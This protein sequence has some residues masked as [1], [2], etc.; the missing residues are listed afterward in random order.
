MVR[1]VTINGLTVN[2]THCTLITRMNFPLICP[3][4]GSRVPFIMGMIACI[5]YEHYMEKSVY[6]RHDDFEI[7]VQIC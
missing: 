6:S 5:S 4:G 7:L 1:I 3:Y 2:R